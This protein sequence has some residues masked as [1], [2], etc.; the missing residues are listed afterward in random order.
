MEERNEYD[1][2]KLVESQGRCYVSSACIQGSTLAAYLKYH[3]DLPRE[4]LLDWMRQILHQLDLFHRSSGNPCYQYINP[5]SILVG[6][7]GKI[8]FIDL[9][10][11]N[12][13]ALLRKME[14]RSIRES[15]LMPDNQY[16]QRTSLADDIYG[17]GRTFQ[18][19]LAAADGSPPVKGREKRK[20]KRIIGRCLHQTPD[21]E[22]KGGWN[23]NYQSIQNISD[24]FPKQRKEKRVIRWVAVPAGAAV[25]L[26]TVFLSAIFFLNS[27]EERTKL[28][29]EKR[30][31]LETRQIRIREKELL[32]DIGMLY[33]FELEQYKKSEEYFEEIREKD[34]LTEGYRKLAAFLGG[35]DKPDDRDLKA[36]LEQIEK[37]IPDQSDYRYYMCL[38][39]GYTL[40]KTYQGSRERI[41]LS[42]YCLS[43][44]GWKSEDRDHRK[45][46]EIRWILARDQGEIRDFDRAADEYEKLLELEEVPAMREQIYL[47][48][49]RNYDSGGD[50]ERAGLICERAIEEFPDSDKMKLTYLEL[51]CRSVQE[52]P[53]ACARIFRSFLEETPMLAG[54]QEFQELKNKYGIQTEE[55]G[56]EQAG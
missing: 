21:P 50:G 20:I 56:G 24:Q 42:K 45:E 43:C 44:P 51:Q 19:M 40:L 22:K 31:A 3:P 7:D 16:Y 37:A 9:G 8:H 30:T 55:P 6:E 1:I 17:L 15:F 13:E 23:R 27:E 12:Q 54:N 33:F 32:F 4:Q 41:R 29:E 26:L 28:E 14:R 38:L 5:Y 10:S 53:E 35:S 34:S 49:V 48:A 25:L 11:G 39:K 36:L 47:E 52:D 46:K 2:L 18:Y